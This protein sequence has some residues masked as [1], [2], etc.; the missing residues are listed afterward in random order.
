MAPVLLDSKAPAKL[1]DG[2]RLAE[3]QIE[4]EDGM[5]SPL[6]VHLVNEGPA[7]L[8]Q[9]LVASESGQLREAHSRAGHDVSHPVVQELIRKGV[10]PVGGG[11]TGLTGATFMN[12]LPAEGQYA[13]EPAAFAQE[14]ERNDM[15]LEQRDFTGLGGAPIDQRISNIGVLAWMRIVFKGTLTVGGSGAVTATYQWPWNVVKRFTLNLNGQTSLV[16]CEGVDL[17]ARRQRVYRNPRE[18][19]SAAPATEAATGNPNPGVIA[20]GT[21]SVVL[22]YDIPIVHDTWSLIGAIFAQSDQTYLNFRATP[23]AQAE[24][25]SVA[26]GGTVALTGKLHSQLTFY[27]IPM[28]DGPKGRVILVPDLRY[29]HGYLSGDQQ[30]ANTGEVNVPFIRT[31][32][33]L[34]TYLFYIDNGGAAQIAPTVPSEVRF[35]YGGNRRPRVNAPVE[36]LLEENVQAYNGLLKPGYLCFDFENHNPEREVVYPKGVTELGTVIT[37]PAGQTVNPNARVHFV[38][39]TLF[40]GR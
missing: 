18:E 15:P 40:A 35:Q 17:R 28:V 21:Y 4:R 31:S 6:D 37:L 34:V 27:D 2:A 10:A 9:R 16:S 23:G 5:P 24:L 11:A 38:E 39:E 36:Q 19:V 12:N 1:P 26:A 13:M 30:F 29:L 3:V 8:P 7:P 14:T 20:N 33:Q 25:F 32:G 22:A